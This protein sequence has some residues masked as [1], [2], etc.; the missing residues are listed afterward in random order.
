MRVAAVQMVSGPDAATNLQQAANLVAQAAQAGA[1]LVV[2]PEYFCLIGLRDTDK[3]QIQ[4]AP[5]VGPLQEGL[6]AL[7]RQYRVWLVG[8]TLPVTA[9]QEGGASAPERVCNRSVVFNP[10]GQSVAHY[11]KMH[12]FRFDNG[13]EAYDE[14]RLLRAGTQPVQ[15]MLPSSDG[16][17]WNVGMAVCYDLRFP[18]LFRHYTAHGA[19]LLLVPSAFTY[20]T[21]QAH[22]ELLLRARAVENVSYV[23]AAAQ[24]GVHASGRQTWGQSMVVDPW[25]DMLAQQAQGLGVVLADIDASRVQQCRQQLPALQHRVLD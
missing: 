22:W 10:D 19:D 16:H 13:R 11:D 23:V 9:A 12:L 15:F 3:L 14:S 2:L 5:G 4:E 8:G 18:E 21:G 1:E 7:A 20:T 17:V 6:A 25:G 24:G